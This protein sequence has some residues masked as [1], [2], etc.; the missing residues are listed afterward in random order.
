MI[1]VV[2]VA[3]AASAVALAGCA[4]TGDIAGGAGS[5]KAEPGQAFVGQRVTAELGERLLRLTG[6]RQLRW[7]PPRT[8]MTMDYRVDRLNVFYDDA[9]MIDRVTCG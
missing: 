9:M 7:G 8:P 3:L 1:R 5:C 2:S 6:A 4:T